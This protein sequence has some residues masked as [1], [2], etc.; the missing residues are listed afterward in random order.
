MNDLKCK[1]CGG[2]IAANDLQIQDPACPHC[3]IPLPPNMGKHPQRKFILFFIGLT[4]FCVVM[5]LWL[6]PDWTRFIKR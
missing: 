3:G 6:P 2:N 4:I 5:I 1:H